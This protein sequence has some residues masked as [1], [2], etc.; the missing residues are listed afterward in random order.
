MALQ[1]LYHRPVVKDYMANVVA[2]EAKF[3]V[4]VEEIVLEERGFGR[5]D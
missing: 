3:R 5:V 2:H 4:F 1:I